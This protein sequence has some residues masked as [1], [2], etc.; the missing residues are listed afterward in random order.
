M[1]S[2]RCINFIL[3]I[4]INWKKYPRVPLKF[5]NLLHDEYCMFCGAQRECDSGRRRVGSGARLAAADRHRVAPHHRRNPTSG[6]PRR[7]HRRLK[8]LSGHR[9]LDT[10]IVGQSYVP[11]VSISGLLMPQSSVDPEFT[12]SSALLQAGLKN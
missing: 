12:A 6:A 8:L 9:T 5:V 3:F 1:C 4:G 7:R 2:Y 11:V 10:I